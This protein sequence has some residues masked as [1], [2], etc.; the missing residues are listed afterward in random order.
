MEG[1]W[2]TGTESDKG[3][4]WLQKTWDTSQVQEAQPRA[5]IRFSGEGEHSLL[6]NG[7]MVDNYVSEDSRNLHQ[8][9]VTD[10]LKHGKNTIIARVAR[11]LTNNSD[12]AKKLPLGFFLDG[13]RETRN[14]EVFDAI[15]TDSS[16]KTST[17][18]AFNESSPNAIIYRYPDSQEFERHFEGNAYLLNFPDFLL[19]NISWAGLGTILAIT[20]AILIGR[21]GL[22]TEGVL[23]S[24]T[25]GAGIMMPGTFFLIGMGLLKHR[26]AESE[27]GLLFAQPSANILILLGFIGIQVI[28]LL[29]SLW[30]NSLNL[31]RG[32][33]NKL[34]AG[35]KNVESTAQNWGWLFSKLQIGR[36]HV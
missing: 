6:L 9:E 13:W 3:E 8:F 19:R 32:K 23:N 21:F 7:Q 18:A 17:D 29:G 30:Y 2:I 25:A 15:A 11:S 1:S 28:T 35:E 34:S 31:Y 22:F 12:D 5:F 16:W 10:L 20:N 36:A 33:I 4:L 24:L 27:M 26:Y 14:G